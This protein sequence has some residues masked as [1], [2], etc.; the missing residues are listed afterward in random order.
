MNSLIVNRVGEGCW[1]RR[2]PGDKWRLGSLRMWGTDYDENEGSYGQ[3]PIGVV[4]DAETNMCHSVSV[5]RICFND[6]QPT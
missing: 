5:S 1:Y 2:S 3:F 6:N 4:E